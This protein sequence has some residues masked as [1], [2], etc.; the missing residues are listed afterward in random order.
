MALPVTILSDVGLAG[1]HPPEKS[2]GG[3]FYAGVRADAD[4]LDVYKATDPTTSFSLQDSA[5]GPVHVGTLLGYAC[6]EDGDVLH[7]VAWSAN[8]YEYYTFNMATDLWVIDENII[9][10][11]STPAPTFPWAS[12]DVRSDGDV[13]VEYAGERDNVMGDRKERVD[14]ARREGGTWT[15]GIAVDHGGDIHFGNPNLVKGPLTDDMHMFWQEQTLL[16]DPPVDWAQLEG[17]TLD[18]SNVLSAIE[19]EPGANTSTNL[20]GYG[21]SPVSYDDAGTQRIVI[22]GT[23]PAL[24]R[25]LLATE[26]AS[27]DISFDFLVS[28]L[29][30]PDPGPNGEV[31]IMS[32]AEL[33][34][35]LHL[36]YRD[37]T[38]FD[39]YYTTS[40][41][42][43]QN[44][45]VPTEEIDAI[46]VNF[47][48][49][50]IYVRGVDTVLAYLYDDAGVQKYNEKILVAGGADDI[51]AVLPIS[52][53]VAA[54]LDAAGTL[55]S[56]QTISA[57]I[58]AALSGAGTLAA[59]NTIALTIA[60]DIKANNNIAAVLPLSAV[61]AAD[62]DATGALAT[63]QSIILSVAA[64]LTAEGKIEA[65]VSLILTV[66]A[67]LRATGNLTASNNLTLS[68]AA[69]LDA[70]GSLAA[71]L[72]LALTV[73]AGLNAVG[74]L[75]AA[76]LII[77][78]VAADI[79]DGAN[80]DLAASLQI[81]L[82][83]T[84]N[85]N[86]TGTLAVS[87][88]LTLSAV[89]D[90]TAQGKLEAANTLVLQLAADLD[91]LGSLSATM[92]LALNVAAN[93]TAKGKIEAAFAITATVAAN[94]TA[95]G[96][97]EATLPITLTVA[98]DLQGAVIEDIAANL[99]LSLTVVSLL[100]G[101]GALIAS[102]PLIL[103]V[104]ADLDALGR[105]DAALSLS[106][107]ITANLNATGK[108]RA[109][110]PISS[111]I[112]AS[113]TARGEL[114][115][116]L[117]ISFSIT[118]PISALGRLDAALVLQLLVSATI[119]DANARVLLN[120]I[121]DIIVSLFNSSQS[122]AVGTINS[123]QQCVGNLR[124]HCSCRWSEKFDLSGTA[125]C[126]FGV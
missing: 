25:M 84:P 73:A 59:A 43:G 87:L 110:L 11:G 17:R 70:T 52:V 9:T 100:S 33:S 67:D 28:D 29:Q 124:Q 58:A 46:T 82:T 41:D 123:E 96:K 50:N 12:I 76:N 117:P 40:T 126:S 114:A 49:A 20:L 86:A 57:A 88:P 60:A 26:D 35:D 24:K 111:T 92:A 42:D 89:A 36:L 15:I 45:A 80:I 79:Q 112:S 39:L 64:D 68:I 6:R 18:P 19:A 31:G 98:A 97:L 109:T 48:S 77:L 105:L 2:S 61:V 34:G 72:T 122:L 56:A 121:Q 71:A 115:A 75:E 78:T 101:S 54:E 27:D 22:A 38:D 30:D 91:A 116:T 47:V 95:Q 69:D 83:T 93:L 74:K 94:L 1:H 4:E 103:N 53:T 23:G 125:L 102:V 99:P 44:W 119:G 63:A 7:I 51:T 85:L 16:T 5:N 65:A 3:A 13:I 14:Y 32:L 81:A 90:L 66:A 55:T 21:A 8:T 108:L 10:I 118:P 106:A 107:L 104:I 113:L 120:S 37:D 62:L